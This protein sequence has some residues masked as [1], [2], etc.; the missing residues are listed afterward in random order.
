MNRLVIIAV[1]GLICCKIKTHYPVIIFKMYHQRTLNISKQF[2]C[3]V[4]SNGCFWNN[5]KI[6]F[7]S[8]HQRCS[9]KKVFLEISENSQKNN[10]ARDA[11]LI[12]LQILLLRPATLFKKESLA[13]VFFCEFCEIS[14]NTFFTEHLWTTASYRSSQLLTHQSHHKNAR[15]TFR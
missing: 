13:Q 5:P 3:K 2:S 11:F 7:R 6:S 8:S 10:C 4:L 12:K 15:T 14:K 1:K 9:V